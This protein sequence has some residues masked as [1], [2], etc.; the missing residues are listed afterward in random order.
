MKGKL[1]AMNNI[2]K[3]E[4]LRTGVT[5]FDLTGEKHPLPAWKSCLE[6]PV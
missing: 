1:Q 2:W 5:L 6:V 4:L 3:P